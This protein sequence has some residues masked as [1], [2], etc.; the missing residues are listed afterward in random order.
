MPSIFDW[1]PDKPVDS[2]VKVDYF[3]SDLNTGSNSFFSAPT[4]SI[5]MTFDQN[6]AFRKIVGLSYFYTTNRNK[7]DI[8]SDN[9]YNSHRISINFQSGFN[10]KNEILRRMSSS[11]TYSLFYYNYVNPDSFS[12]FTRRVN[13]TNLLTAGLTYGFRPN[14]NFY[15]NYF[16]QMNNSNLPVGFVF[17]ARDRVEGFQA[18]PPPRP[19]VYKAR[20]WATFR[21]SRSPL[22]WVGVLS[23]VRIDGVFARAVSEY[24]FYYQLK[25][26]CH[27]R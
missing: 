12:N 25:R 26:V 21:G 9:A 27:G 11:V 24:D 6:F 15:L 16:Y 3:Y 19:S 7:Q 10:S 13:V 18:I 4:T 2:S 20:R 1:N 5:G 14:I 17:S 22:A 8:G 23:P